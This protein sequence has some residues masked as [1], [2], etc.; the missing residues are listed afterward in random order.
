MSAH[1]DEDIERE[2]LC[3]GVERAVAMERELLGD[4]RGALLKDRGV[5]AR[6]AL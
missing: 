1:V 4:A 5:Y 3:A 2:V 6:G